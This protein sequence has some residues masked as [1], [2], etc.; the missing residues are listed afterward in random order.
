MLLGLQSCWIVFLSMTKRKVLSEFFWPMK[1]R[2]L[3]TTKFCRELAVGVEHTLLMELK[4]TS[5]ATFE[6]LSVANGQY[7]QAVIDTGEEMVT[8]GMHA[9]KDP[10]EGNFATFSNIL[11]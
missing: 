1:Q 6:Y 7:S 8:L 5:K 4:D 10:S 2:N 11:C 9:N 3:K